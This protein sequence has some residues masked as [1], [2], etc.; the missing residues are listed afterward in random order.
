MVSQINLFVPKTHVLISV[1]SV[2][3]WL[4]KKTQNKELCI[5]THSIP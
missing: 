2:Y 4:L 1:P 5:V 3:V